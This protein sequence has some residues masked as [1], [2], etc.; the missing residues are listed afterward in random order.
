VADISPQ[1]LVERLEAQLSSEVLAALQ[2]LR[3]LTD[4]ASL[5]LYLVGGAVRDLVMR[6]D[7][8]D[9]DL[10]IEADVAPIA[11]ALAA[12]TGSKCTLHR[13]FGTAA[14]SGQG[15]HLDLARTRKETYAHPGALPAVEPA[16]I[17]D[18]LARRDF[19]INAMALR[20]NEAPL[21]IDPHD[22]LSGIGRKRIAVLHDRSFQDDAT[23]MLRAVRYAARLGFE[24]DPQAESWLRR[25]LSYLDPISG[26]RL[27][28]ELRLIFDEP[29]AVA[30]AQTAEGLG[31]LRGV[32]EALAL[33]DAVAGHWRDAF[34][35]E[36]LAS[37]DETS[38]CILAGYAD[39]AAITSLSARLHLAG[40]FQNAL[41]DAVRL[42]N[43]SS[44]LAAMRQDPVA[45]VDML[46]H[47]VPSAVWATGIVAGGETAVTCETYLR[48]WR[49]VRSLLR[50]DDLIALGVQ[51]GV[52]VG[53]ALRALRDARLTGKT[54]TRESE[55]ALVGAMLQKTGR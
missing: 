1:G 34:A 32:H 51:P 53:E 22:G 20:L 6:R 28:R 44:K 21:L 11:E 18:D 54:A 30:A 55:E 15:W 25:D 40:R 24:L 43:E 33:P 35:G 16:S 14:I 7:N 42:R 46:E 17:E 19:T 26:P 5:D 10:A 23:R 48:E 31:L 13:R 52:A 39:D 12:Q 4:A 47:A 2:T 29:T 41:R 27:R 37:R 3:R 50:G 9:L 49:H 8:V 45:A 38:L 36:A